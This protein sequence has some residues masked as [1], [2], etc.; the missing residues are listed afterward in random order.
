[1]ADNSYPIEVKLASKAGWFTPAEA[2]S[3]YGKYSRDGVTYH[4]W[5][6]I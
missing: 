4:W 6:I 1:M 3:Y 2:K 5:E